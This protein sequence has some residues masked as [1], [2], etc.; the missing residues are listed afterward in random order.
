MRYQCVVTCALLG[1]GGNKVSNAG[2]GKQQASEEE[3]EVLRG[4]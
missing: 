4:S 2:A 1:D 3:H